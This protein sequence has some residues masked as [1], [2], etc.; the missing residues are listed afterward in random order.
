MSISRGFRIL[1]V[2]LG[3]LIAANLILMNMKDLTPFLDL[4]TIMQLPTGL[5]CSTQCSPVHVVESWHERIPNIVQSLAQASKPSMASKFVF[6]HIRKAGGTTIRQS[7]FDAGQHYGFP[8][9]IPCHNG[10]RCDNYFIP[11][12]EKW[13]LAGGH[14]YYTDIVNGLGFTPNGVVHSEQPF[15]CLVSIRPTVSRVVSCWNHRFSNRMGVEFVPAD[16]VTAEEWEQTLPTLYSKHREGCNNEFFRVFG[17]IANEQRVNTMTSWNV[18]GI[19]KNNNY[20]RHE[21]TRKQQQCVLSTELDGVLSKLSQFIVTMQ[22]RC[23]D[24]LIVI[25]HYAPWLERFFPK[26][27]VKS[28]VGSINTTQLTGGSEEAILEQNAL[29]EHVFQFAKSLF[30]EQLQIS[31]ESAN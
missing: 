7:L 12:N 28:N 19:N 30:E 25:K 18:G 13:A 8:T 21:N 9:F 26:C 1:I 5:D 15:N 24:N 29:D 3:L 23:E 31:I 17:D 2:T 27:G 16:E 10:V 22:D 11:V 4:D 6:F 20:Y 14:L